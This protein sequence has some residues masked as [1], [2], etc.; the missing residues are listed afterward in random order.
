MTLTAG[1]DSPGAIQMCISNTATCASWTAL[2]PTVS[3][4]LTK[5]DGTKTVSVWFQDFWGNETSVPYSDT[6]ILDT[7]APGDGAVTATTSDG[8]VTL[9]W[10]GFTDPGSRIEN[11]KVV[12]ATGKAHLPVQP[13]RQS[14]AAETRHIPMQG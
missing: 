8:Q 2:A 1:D 5:G 10:A 11:Y 3:W 13:G 7:V 12:Y 6:I 14:I 4:M 9:E